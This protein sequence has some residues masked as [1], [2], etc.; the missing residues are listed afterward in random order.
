MKRGRRNDFDWVFSAIQLLGVLAAFSLIYAPLRQ[1]LVQL[2][3]M[4]IVLALF[5]L[6]VG[7]G[8]LIV[9]LAFR[10]RNSMSA[11]LRVHDLSTLE[12]VELESHPCH[13][14]SLCSFTERLRTMDW[15]QFEKIVAA[16][17]RKAG[18]NV[19]RR[20]G[21][22]PDGGIDLIL[23]KD[24]EQI[25][26]QCKHWKTRDVGVRV[27]REFLGALMDAGLKKGVFVTLCGS[28]GEAKQ[29]AERHGIEIL[30]ETAVVKML[31]S[32]DASYDPQMLAILNDTT[33]YCPKCESV[34]VL[35][36]AAQGPNPGSQFWGCSNYPGCRFTMPVSPV[37][38]AP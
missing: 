22:N 6:L 23:Q 37:A 19:T 3:V 8:I 18:Y 30:N 34:M 38:G 2:G 9:R 26:V 1:L 11:P 32:I 36:T 21:A 10:R 15:F 17:Y 5:A 29:L 7:T 33:K 28:T 12:P 13:V 20:G 14:P 31:E 4:A 24:G 25:A 16:A 35:R 27:V